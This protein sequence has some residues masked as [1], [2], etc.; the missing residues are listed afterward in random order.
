[1]MNWT[2][3]WAPVWER[4]KDGGGT[5]LGSVG[6]FLVIEAREPAEK[7]GAKPIAKLTSVTSDRTARK[8]GQAEHSLAVQWNAISPQL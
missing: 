4:Q 7:R 1:H 8:D 2:K 6:A 5:I 3:P